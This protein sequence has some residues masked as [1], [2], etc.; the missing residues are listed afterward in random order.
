[1]L[2]NEKKKKNKNKSTECVLYSTKEA[3]MSDFPKASCSP[4][5]LTLK[6]RQLGP[7]HETLARSMNG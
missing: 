3:K 5:Q 6:A 4:V 2:F 1:M 7:C